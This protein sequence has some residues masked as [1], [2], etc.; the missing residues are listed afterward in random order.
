LNPFP[1]RRR[2]IVQ[3]RAAAAVEEPKHEEVK[4]IS[5]PEEAPVLKGRGLCPKCEVKPNH[6]FH[7]KHCKG[8]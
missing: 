8:K 1:G 5:Q 7:V 2:S 6:F 4:E 3:Q